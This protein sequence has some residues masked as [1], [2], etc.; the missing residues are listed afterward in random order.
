MKHFSTERPNKICRGTGSAP[1]VDTRIRS[2]SGLR[3]SQS[4]DP[5][6][7]AAANSAKGSVL[8]VAPNPGWCL[9]A[10]SRTV[11]YTIR[12]PA[13]N[14]GRVDVVDAAQR[15][16]VVVTVDHEQRQGPILPGHRLMQIVA[17]QVAGSRRGGRVSGNS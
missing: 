10:V 2:R 3:P 12:V 5:A 9:C 6:V 13:G 17:A 1:R 4:I 8:A 11:G 7:S 16:E 14:E 15:G